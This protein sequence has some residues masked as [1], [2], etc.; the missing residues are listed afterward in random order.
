MQAIEGSLDK[1]DDDDEVEEAE[2]LK[3]AMEMSLDEQHVT[4]YEALAAQA[5][6][7]ASHFLAKPEYKIP[8]KS[9]I[10]IFGTGAV[11]LVDDYKR[12]HQGS[13]GVYIKELG[14]N[15]SIKPAY[16]HPDSLPIDNAK[17]REG[18]ERLA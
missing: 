18:L 16:I 1:S 2:D 8:D 17:A 4:V 6:I 14:V 12:R 11:D 13:F 9:Q 10:V 15:N 7:V 5:R 3:R